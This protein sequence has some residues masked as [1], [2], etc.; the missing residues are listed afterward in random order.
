M[1]QS[2]LPRRLSGALRRVSGLRPR[3]GAYRQQIGEISASVTGILRALSAIPSPPPTDSIRIVHV[4]DIHNNPMA[5]DAIKAIVEQSGA[6]AVIDTGD[7]GDWGRSFESATFARIA[8][9]PVPYLFLK[10]NH[11]GPR[12]L[13]ELAKIS[14]VRV[15]DDAIPVDIRGLRLI[16]LRDPRFTPD[17]STGDDHYA[18]EKLRTLG[19]QFATTVKAAEADV[20]L[21]HDPIIGAQLAGVV[22][23]VLAGHTHVR[24]ERAR[25][26]TLF[27]T[28]GSSGGAGLRGVRQEPPQDLT[29]TTL[30]FDAQSRRLS[31]VDEYTI[32]GIS[33]RTV[34]LQRR[35]AAELAKRP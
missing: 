3:F 9:I 21:V 20:A 4:S 23:L 35:D 32:G 33:L 19:T 6:D 18:K 28:Q 15:I 24:A 5:Y 27:L 11:D 14:S 13:I 29:I 8:R 10:G 25:E 17:K 2:L 16:G 34:T 12:T 22:P 31:A 7:I 1:S 30:Y 26:G